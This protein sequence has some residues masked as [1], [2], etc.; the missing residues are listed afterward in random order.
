MINTTRKSPAPTAPPGCE[1][2]GSHIQALVRTLPKRVVVR[3]PADKVSAGDLLRQVV[4]I[5]KRIES[6]RVKVKAA[7]LETCRQIDLFF[8]PFL[9]ACD[10]K[11]HEIDRALITFDEL[12]RVKAEAA[13][14]LERKQ[15]AIQAKNEG[16]N[17]RETK[18]LIATVEVMATTYLE[19]VPIVDR[20]DFEIYDP[21]QLKRAYL[22][23]DG[24]AIRA[25]LARL[26]AEGY[27]VE[28]I[29]KEN[30]LPGVRVW[31]ERGTRARGLT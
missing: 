1:D 2:E 29:I 12:E 7:A 25:E 21:T 17:R 10:A 15:L 19:G 26:R 20:W 3:S 18:E 22:M 16:L 24:T 31:I 23:P 28:W 4:T 13:A 14:A 9:E 6:A 8:K 5:R 30:A 11:R 27:T